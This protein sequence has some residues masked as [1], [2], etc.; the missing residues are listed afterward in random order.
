M[1]NHRSPF[2]LQKFKQGRMIFISM[3]S[4]KNMNEKKSIPIWEKFTLTISEASEYFNLG[5]KK[6]RF[7][8]DNYNDYGF[9]LQN[10]N[11]LL[12]KR[13]KFEDFIN[14]TNAV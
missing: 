10:G 6:M 5:E 2:L 12:I 4:N 7:L 14:E 8:A 11:K 9:V 13:R 3:T 1:V